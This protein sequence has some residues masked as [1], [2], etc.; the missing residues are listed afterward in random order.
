MDDKLCLLLQQVNKRRS[1]K[2]SFD[3]VDPRNPHNI[4]FDLDMYENTH[5]EQGISKK[6]REKKQRNQNL[7]QM[8][9]ILQNYEKHSRNG[10]ELRNNTT[11]NC[12]ESSL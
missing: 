5:R 9:N 3:G 7:K 11:T 2:I 10:F 1:I 4:K 8:K 6:D 12:N